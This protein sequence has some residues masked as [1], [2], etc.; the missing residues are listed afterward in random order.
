MLD[1]D[2]SRSSGDEAG[3]AETQ[4][5]ETVKSKAWIFMSSKGMCAQ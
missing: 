2:A 1:D 4:T 5:V 3:A